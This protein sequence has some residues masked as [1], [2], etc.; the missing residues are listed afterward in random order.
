M[1]FLFEQRLR[2][3]VSRNLCLPGEAR[4]NNLPCLM[5][6]RPE[7]FVLWA[8]LRSYLQCPNPLEIRWIEMF[9]VAIIVSALAVSAM[10]FVT[11]FQGTLTSKNSKN[12]G[13]M[14]VGQS[15]APLADLRGGSGAAPAP[16]HVVDGVDQQPRSM[17][18]FSGHSGIFLCPCRW[19]SCTPQHSTSHTAGVGTTSCI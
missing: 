1:R 4:A 2:A 15:A 10:F 18:R 13:D 3:Q 6:Q 11:L 16:K 12:S 19:P 8:K 17:T 7:S 9:L 5:D 14:R